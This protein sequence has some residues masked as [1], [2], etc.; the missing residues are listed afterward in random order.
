MPREN[1]ATKSGIVTGAVMAKLH[2]T[3]SSFFFSAV[4][5]HSS[6]NLP[7]PLIKFLPFFGNMMLGLL[8]L[9]FVL[10]RLVFLLSS[11]VFF[12]AIFWQHQSAK[13][14]SIDE[15]AECSKK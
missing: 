3:A 6:R 15:V 9:L 14:N 2:G 1:N 13:N 5:F 4:P 12:L 8:V 11:F 10:V 7:P